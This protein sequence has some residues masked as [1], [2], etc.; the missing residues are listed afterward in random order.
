MNECIQNM[1][2]D[3]GSGLVSNRLYTVTSANDEV[4]GFR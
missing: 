1:R 2:I 3:S 4:T